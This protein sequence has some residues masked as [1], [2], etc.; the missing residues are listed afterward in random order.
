[1]A[2]N[3]SGVKAAV[4]AHLD[5][6]IDPP[7]YRQGVPDANVLRRDASGRVPYYLTVQFGMPQGKARGKTFSGVRH[8]DYVLPIYVQV[9]GPD[10]AIVEEIAF[11]GVLD[12][13]LGFSTRWTSQMEQRAGGAIYVMT[14]SNAATEAYVYPLS[15][16]LTFQM[17]PDG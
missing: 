6:E 9:V 11:D 7:I 2:L 13:M 3:I 5:S 17:N 12:A 4:F 1:M 16:G 15:F 14:Q 8:D 10:A